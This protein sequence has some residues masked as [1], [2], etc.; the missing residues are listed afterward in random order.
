[1][2]KQRVLTALVLAPIMIGGIFLLPLKPFA[3][4][5]AAIATLGAWEWANIA[6][7][8]RTWSRVLYALVVFV[9]LYISARLL[10]VFPEWL[11]VYLA[12]GTL[13]WA[14]AFALVHR[15]PGGTRVWQARPM[16]AML[17][18]CVL[19]PMWVGF[20][21]LKEQPHSSLLIFYVML[22]VWGADTGAYFSGKR[23]GNTK[24]APEVSPGKSWAGFWGGFATTLAIAAG[25]G[26]YIHYWV[27]PMTLTSS[28]KLLVITVVTM[29]I[30][31][32]GDLVESMMKRHRGIKDSS[33]MLPGHGGVLDRIDSMAAAVPVFAFCMVVL[34][35]GLS[36]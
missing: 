14:L 4:F 15:Y 27:E 32:L 35:W 17:G 29:V 8:Q 18:L 10:R 26:T 5:I 30:S 24:L 34:N 3:F 20:M 2:F 36:A 28:W 31:V 23:W 25:F 16:R 1:M 21:H 7:Y 33:S 19:I 11:I 12:L 22:I 6:G 13:W 9:C